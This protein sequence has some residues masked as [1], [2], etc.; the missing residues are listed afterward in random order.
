MT[1]SPRLQAIIDSIERL[2]AEKAEISSM[3]REQKDAAK[4]LGYSLPVLNA[5][6][7]LRK[8]PLHQRREHEALVE[9]YKAELGM[10]QGTPLGDA[11]ISRLERDMK[12]SPAFPPDEPAA[13]APVPDETAAPAEPAT[14]P[15][16]EEQ[17]RQKGS[18]AATAGEPIVAN[19]YP[20]R[21]ALRAAWDEAWCQAK[22]SDGMD[23]PD[24]WRPTPKAPKKPKPS[25]EPDGA[26]TD[27]GAG[28]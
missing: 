10:L 26:G 15:D 20:P 18:D 16:T 24:A 28:E 4:S 11:A 6:L 3:I 21:S 8:M 7:K 9:I 1:N 23:L 12:P 19:P 25:D 17:S 13:D 27:G 22:G 14:P 5:V 2:E